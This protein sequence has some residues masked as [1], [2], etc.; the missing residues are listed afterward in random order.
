MHAERAPGI[1]KLATGEGA[2]FLYFSL[3]IIAISAFNTKVAAFSFPPKRLTLCGFGAAV[4]GVIIYSVTLS[5]KITTFATA[6]ALL[7]G[8]LAATALWRSAFLGKNT[9]SR[10]ALLFG[11]I[12]IAFS[13]GLERMLPLWMLRQAVRCADRRG[14]RCW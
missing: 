9:Q 2:I 8:T 12:I 10:F 3:F 4:R 14:W 7:P 1:L 5:H 11:E 6:A 13:A